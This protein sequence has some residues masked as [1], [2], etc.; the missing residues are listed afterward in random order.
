MAANVAYAYKWHC[1]CVC[2]SECV[3][4]RRV[5]ECVMIKSD[6]L[7]APERS[8]KSSEREAVAEQTLSGLA[9]HHR[10]HA[11]HK[12]PKLAHTTFC[13]MLI[14]VSYDDDA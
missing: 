8:R 6:T 14:A 4:G 5:C 7:P 10:E 11:P 12:W 3:S 2:E 1:V 9:Y 13:P